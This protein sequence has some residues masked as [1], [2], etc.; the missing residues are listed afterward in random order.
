MTPEQH[1]EIKQHIIN[2]ANEEI[3]PRFERASINFKNDGSIVTET[4]LAVQRRLQDFL[5]K[6]TPDIPF[7]GEEMSAEK[8]NQLIASS[9]SGLW[10]L[11]PLDGTSNYASGIPFF[12]ISLALLKNN[13]PVL[14]IIY[15]PMRKEYFMAEQNKGAWL[16][17]E[18]LQCNDDGRQLNKSMAVVDFKR[19]PATLA[20]ELATQPPFA[21]Q[22][23]FGS[24]ALD[25]CW[26]AANRYHVYLHGK[27]KSWDYA[28][29]CL[30]LREAGGFACT[31]EGERVDDGSLT[32]RS[33]VASNSSRLF[34]QWKKVANTSN[35]DV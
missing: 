11:D 2:I 3:I 14:G 10:C 9:A 26:L 31:L 30:I 12:A 15:D 6:L 7:L 24:V 34:S 22:R 19:L 35:F 32:A 17:D 5:A 16:N 8:Q 20:T 25:W 13:Q 28:A 29:G 1:R 27:Q 23:S 4:D 33:A 21:S 18:Q